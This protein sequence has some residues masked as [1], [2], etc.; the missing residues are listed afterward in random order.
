MR[1]E[2][3]GK[4]RDREMAAV[5]GSDH[6]NFWAANQKCSGEENLWRCITDKCWMIYLS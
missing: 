3:G 6:L 1:E 4:A 2:E 5:R